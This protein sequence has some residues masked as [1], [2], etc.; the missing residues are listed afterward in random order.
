MTHEPF[1]CIAQRVG[2]ITRPPVLIRLHDDVCPNRILLDVPQTRNPVALVVDRLGAKSA[3][4][5]RS[6]ALISP[7]EVQHVSDAEL[8]HRGGCTDF[9]A[10]GDLQVRMRRHQGEA[11]HRDLV[12]R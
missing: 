4:P 1:D 9:C 10:G 5:Q 6:D 7:I 11:M 8:L 2:T 3:R 12:T